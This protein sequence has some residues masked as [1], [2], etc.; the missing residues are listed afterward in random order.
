MGNIEVAALLDSDGDELLLETV[1]EG[2]RWASSLEPFALDGDGKSGGGTG[3]EDDGI[4]T[5]I[6]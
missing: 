3:S 5:D 4:A 6:A 1:M 2:S